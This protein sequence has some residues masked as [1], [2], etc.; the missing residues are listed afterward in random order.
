MPDT[1]MAAL[2]GSQ[3][4][5][6]A[7]LKRWI[8]VVTHS[9]SA[10][11]PVEAERLQEFR[12]EMKAVLPDFMEQVVSDAIFVE[13]SSSRETEFSDM[14]TFKDEIFSRITKCR[15]VD[16][17]SFRAT[18]LDDVIAGSLQAVMEHYPDLRKGLNHMKKEELT[19]LYRFLVV[20][21]EKN[22]WLEITDSILPD[23]DAFRDMWNKLN[24]VARDTVAM[25]VATR[26]KEDV[27]AETNKSWW[28]HFL[29]EAR[30]RSSTESKSNCAVQ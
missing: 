1:L 3:E 30:S 19:S 24:I 8:I 2:T 5:K 14:A 9:D 18:K 6:F 26:V 16:Q 22:R 25:E 27:H 29:D 15:Q 11:K 4:Q 10:R 12:R 13:L 7:L 21:S 20:V 17:R 28:K 23:G